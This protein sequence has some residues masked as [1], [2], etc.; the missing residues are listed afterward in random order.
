MA[1]WTVCL[2]YQAER[3]IADILAWTEEHFSRQQAD[4]YAE[5]LTSALATLFDG[6][7]A[8]GAK[9]RDDILPG[10]RVLHVAR[11]GKRGRHYIVFRSE[12]ACRIDVL[13]IL[14]DS[15]DLARH[16]EI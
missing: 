6:P 3:D 16:I 15:M 12:E 7:D 10:I 4:F 14:H 13:R 5:I 2:A 8:I 9:E 1:A 11:Q